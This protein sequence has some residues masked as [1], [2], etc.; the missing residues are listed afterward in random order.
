MDT[1]IAGGMSTPEIID[2]PVDREGAGG[3]LPLHLGIAEQFRVPE[4]HGERPE[5]WPPVRP[6]F[7]QGKLL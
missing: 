1:A 4:G 5:E 7:D 2:M 6:S 3:Q